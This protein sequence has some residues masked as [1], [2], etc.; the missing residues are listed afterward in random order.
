MRWPEDSDAIID[1]LHEVDEGDKVRIVADDAVFIGGEF[2]RGDSMM[3]DDVGTVVDENDSSTDVELDATVIE[4]G[5][6]H[7]TDATVIEP[8]EEDVQED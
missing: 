3:I 6:D 2:K 7:L 8:G 4:P 5:D 1:L